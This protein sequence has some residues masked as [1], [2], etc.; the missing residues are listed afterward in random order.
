MAKRRR[1]SSSDLIDWNDP[2]ANSHLLDWRKRA[3]EFGLVPVEDGE[4]GDDS[5][6]LL[7]VERLL[8][9]EEPE[10]ADDQDLESSALDNSLGDE[11]EAR[12]EEDLSAQ[13]VDLVRLYLTNISQHRL[14]KAAEEQEIGRRIELA[15]GDLLAEVV[16]IPCGRQTL[17]ALARNVRR[18][19]PG[20]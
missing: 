6:Q 14:L 1:E 17:L 18:C 7:P 15:R 11:A 10:A 3:H 16:S 20:G 8:N 5:T 9:E 4:A 19:G 2:D 13:D 12:I